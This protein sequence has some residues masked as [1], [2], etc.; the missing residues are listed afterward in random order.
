M[1]SNPRP[2]ALL[3][4]IRWFTLA[5]TLVAAAAL[6]GILNGNARAEDEGFEGGSKTFTNPF[7]PGGGRGGSDFFDDEDFED[8]SPQFPAGVQRPSAPGTAA[9]AG[10]T[11]TPPKA[12]AAGGDS[13]QTTRSEPK[14]DVLKIDDET[15]LGPGGKQIVNEFNYPD[16]DILD[17]AKTLG[18]LTG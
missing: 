4:P 7:A 18:K 9:Q 6:L 15:G 13:T 12:T 1:T 14:V 2:D 8:D 17:L 10:G 3:R 16:A 5:S 11:G